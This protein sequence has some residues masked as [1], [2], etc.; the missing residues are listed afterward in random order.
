MAGNLH[1]IRNN[2]ILK[3][4]SNKLENLEE[5]VKVLNS[6]TSTL[7][8]RLNKMEDDRKKME[9]NQ[10]SSSLPKIEKENKSNVNPI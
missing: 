9:L 8:D 5:N 10:F 3:A 7:I 6:K 4:N 2:S 1:P